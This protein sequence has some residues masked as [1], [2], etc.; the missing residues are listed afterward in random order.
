M[1]PHSPSTPAFG[2]TPATTRPSRRPT[3]RM[4]ADCICTRTALPRLP[5]LAASGGARLKV[6]ENCLKQLQQRLAYLIDALVRHLSAVRRPRMTHPHALPY[7]HCIWRILT[8][9][10]QCSH[11]LCPPV[12]AHALPSASRY[13]TA[14]QC[15]HVLVSPSLSPSL[16]PPSRGAPASSAWPTPRATCR[17]SSSPRSS[18]AP[19]APRSTARLPWSS[20]ARASRSASGYASTSSWCA[21]PPLASRC[22]LGTGRSSACVHAFRPCCPAKDRSREQ[23]RGAAFAATRPAES[24]PFF[25]LCAHSR[26]SEAQ[27]QCHVCTDA[28]FAT[29]DRRRRCSARC[30]GSCSPPTGRSSTS[31]RWR[32]RG[33][34][35]SRRPSR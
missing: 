18:S 19:S 24:A 25:G 30:R 26:A 6:M 34:T 8:R 15:S 22:R 5:Q 11:A 23:P 12:H 3:H 16:P 35:T 2:R 9:H 17:P 13:A 4:S 20:R 21:S 29:L 10:S 1:P 28:V 14:F 31:R 27:T 33:C 32:W 7:S